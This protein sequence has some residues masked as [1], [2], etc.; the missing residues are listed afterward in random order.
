MVD[1]FILENL[2]VRLMKESQIKNKDNIKAVI[3]EKHFVIVV[4]NIQD[5]L[6]RKKVLESI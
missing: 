3:S 6:K 2:Q 5:S 1:S 4:R